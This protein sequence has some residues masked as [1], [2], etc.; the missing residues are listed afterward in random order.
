MYVGLMSKEG[1]KETQAEGRAYTEPRGTGGRARQEQD[2]LEK[3]GKTWFHRD[4]D[5][6]GGCEAG[7]ADL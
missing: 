3:P 5:P 7:I 4:G 2:G 6:E 1:N